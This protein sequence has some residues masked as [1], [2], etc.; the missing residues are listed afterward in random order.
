MSTF[1]DLV[2]TTDPAIYQIHTAAAGPKGVCR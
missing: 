1:A 2:E